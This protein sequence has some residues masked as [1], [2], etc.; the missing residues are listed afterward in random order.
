MP[1]PTD[2]IGRWEYQAEGSTYQRKF[3]ADGTVRA[4]D[5]KSNP[6][7]SFDGFRWRI[8][9]DRIIAE[10]PGREITITHALMKE[11]TLNFESAGFGSGK[12]LP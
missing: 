3:L 9:G 6:L 10:H 1:K 5:A 8:D 12:R 4:L 2:I 11:G 7:T